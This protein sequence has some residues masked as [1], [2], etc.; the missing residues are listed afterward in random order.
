MVLFGVLVLKLVIQLGA[1]RGMFSA[2]LLGCQVSRLLALVQ[3]AGSLCEHI[4]DF[5]LGIVGEPAL[6]QGVH[7]YLLQKVVVLEAAARAH[8]LLHNIRKRVLLALGCN[9]RV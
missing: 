5:V 8:R 4:V 2:P 3:V 6:L 9:F 1:P 7:D